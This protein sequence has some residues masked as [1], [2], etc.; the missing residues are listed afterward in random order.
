MV[1]V[2]TVAAWDG[3][4]ISGLPSQRR[5]AAKAARERIADGSWSETLSIEGE[6]VAA[7]V[8]DLLERD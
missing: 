8:V 6:V 2:A 5:G 7:R 3:R 4:A 1:R